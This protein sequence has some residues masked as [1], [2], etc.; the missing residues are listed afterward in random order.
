[1]A[2]EVIYVQRLKG[3]C[4]KLP[5][6]AKDILTVIKNA[7]DKTKQLIY[8]ELK[9]CECKQVKDIFGDDV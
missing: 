3:E 7:D 5:F 6:N 1:M 2:V 8:D 9:Q 4:N